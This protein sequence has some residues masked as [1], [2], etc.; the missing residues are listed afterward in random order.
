M[1]AQNNVFE[2]E[3]ISLSSYVGSEFQ[4]LIDGL[5]H[6]PSTT[7]LYGRSGSMK[8]LL[9]LYLAGC[10]ATGKHVFNQYPT[11][12]ANVFYL[13]GELSA[14]SINTRARMLGL[15]DIPKSQLSYYQTAD[16]ENFTL[17]DS[18]TRNTL[19]SFLKENHYTVL[20]IDN[21]RVCFDLLN[22]NAAESWQDINSFLKRLRT[23]GITV[24]LVH[25]SGKNGDFSGSS[26]ATTV[27]DYVVG[28]NSN[29][30]ISRVLHVSKDREDYGCHRN[31]NNQSL[32]F[33]DGVFHCGDVFT[34]TPQQ[35]ILHIEFRLD[36]NSYKNK[37]ELVDD[38]IELGLLS[39]NRNAQTYKHIAAL[40]KT[41]GINDVYA[42]EMTLKS[43]I[44]GK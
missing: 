37:K 26:N 15:S 23:N 36:T 31:L 16:K 34:E 32:L 27:V 20:I 5:I 18:E 29:D 24:I 3:S 39:T 10:I 8:S 17:S 4:P 19:I 9:C 21:V 41:Y 38:L 6:F 35:K 28:I 33:N 1:Q 11:T 25:H 13:D 43:H 14:A 44:L 40:F 12:Q 22:E 2:F 42:S 30:S 7:L